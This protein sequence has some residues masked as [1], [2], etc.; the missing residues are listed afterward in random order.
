MYCTH[1]GSETVNGTCPN[2]GQA[3]TKATA[4]TYG[5]FWRRVGAT[6][7]DELILYPVAIAL[8]VLPVTA[9]AATAIALGVQAFYMIKLLA[10][11]RGQTIGNRVAGTVVR[12]ATTGNPATTHQILRRWALS[13]V[14]AL[15]AVVCIAVTKNTLLLMLVFLDD[16]WSLRSPKRQTLHDIFADTVVLR[17]AS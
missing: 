9:M 10:S 16:A 11:P 2:C 3:S 4:T 14:L 15:A 5:G 6:L 7:I 1:C 13:T 17:V 8:L 12:D